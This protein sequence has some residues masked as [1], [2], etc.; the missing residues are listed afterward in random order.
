[1]PINQVGECLPAPQFQRR[2][3]LLRRLA[4]SVRGERGPALPDQLLEPARI[5]LTLRE[6]EAVRARPGHHDGPVSRR[7]ERLAQPRDVHVEGVLGT[8][9]RLLA[10]QLM[11]KHVTRD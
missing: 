8:D 10:P 11:D 6:L 1:M 3:Q 9:R 7:V 4:G 5:Q 2:A